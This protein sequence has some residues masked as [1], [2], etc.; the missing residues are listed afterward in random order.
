[1]SYVNLS[2]VNP[3]L[4]QYLQSNR[5]FVQLKIFLK[6]DGLIYLEIRVVMQFVSMFLVIWEA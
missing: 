5:S 3:F 1:M 6:K 4:K 2:F